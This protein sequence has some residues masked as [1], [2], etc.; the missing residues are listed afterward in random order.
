MPPRPTNKRTLS[1]RQVQPN[2]NSPNTQIQRRRNN[3]LRNPIPPVPT[4]VVP[5]PAPAPQP[6]PAPEKSET[7]SF[8]NRIQ[9]TLNASLNAQAAAPVVA[10]PAPQP[11]QLPA[12]PAQV[13][14]QAQALP[15]PPA[16]QASVPV[17]QKNEIKVEAPKMEQKEKENKHEI[18]LSALDSQR[19]ATSRAA[20][21][22]SNNADAKSKMVK[23]VMDRIPQ[24]LVSEQNIAFVLDT[25]LALVGEVG[26]VNLIQILMPL[27]QL[28]AQLPG[29][30]KLPTS[31]IVVVSELYKAIVNVAYGGRV[32]QDMAIQAAHVVPQIVPLVMVVIKDKKLVEQF[33]Q[34]LQ[35]QQSAKRAAKKGCCL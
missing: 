14:A 20:S 31:Q 34:S 8:L 26:P 32:P 28:V 33:R 35:A 21:L 16:S 11:A 1:Q 13:P 3:T 4:P 12:A 19:V 22:D 10:S 17:P 15:S 27:C 2:V 6:A 5:T 24:N 9:A 18:Q 25:I 23:Q 30:K 7:K 29:M